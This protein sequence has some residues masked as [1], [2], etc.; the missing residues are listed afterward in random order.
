MACS[1]WPTQVSI[2]LLAGV[3]ISFLTT[4]REGLPG[5]VGSILISRIST[6]LHSLASTLPPISPNGWGEGKRKPSLKLVIG[7]L[8]FVTLPIEIG[9]LAVLRGVGWLEIPFLFIAFFVLFFCVSVRLTPHLASLPSTDQLI[10]A[11]FFFVL[12]SDTTLNRS[13]PPCQS[14]SSS[15][16]SSGQKATTQT[17]T[18][19]Q[20]IQRRWT[21][22]VN[23]SSWPVTS[24]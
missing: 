13:E 18:P 24:S 12:C 15:Q 21:S 3:W 6:S 10:P 4:E 22:P 19:C 5:G 2:E 17:R 16:T 9:F 20:Y 7:T 11:S 1:R 14:P 23:C 8:F